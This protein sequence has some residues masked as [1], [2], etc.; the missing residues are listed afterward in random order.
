MYGGSLNRRA[1]VPH[2]A[3]VELERGLDRRPGAQTDA[4]FILHSRAVL[5]RDHKQLLGVEVEGVDRD[6][7]LLGKATVL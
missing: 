2:P 3:A 7:G 1:R 5:L 4:R 6:V